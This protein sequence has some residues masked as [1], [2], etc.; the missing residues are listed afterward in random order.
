MKFYV[1]LFALV[2]T[3]GAC[4]QAKQ[5]SDAAGMDLTAELTSALSKAT[6]LLGSVTDASSAESAAM[7]IESVNQDL[8]DIAAD[9]E[10]ATPEVQKSVSETASAQIPGLQDLVDQAYAVPGVKPVLQ[11]SVDAMMSK[12]TGLM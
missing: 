2:F 4:S 11:P 1:A 5:V 10:S 9:L 8:D 12:L 6:S 3:L 7:D